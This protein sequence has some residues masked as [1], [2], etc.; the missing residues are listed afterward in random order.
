LLD[1]AKVNVLQRHPLLVYPAIVPQ[2]HRA[3]KVVNQFVDNAMSKS[4]PQ[5]IEIVFQ[6]WL[7]FLMH[8]A[9]LTITHGTQSLRLIH[10]GL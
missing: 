8:L 7:H 5:V 1:S 10:N 6:Y 3:F 4:G 2:S 9:Q